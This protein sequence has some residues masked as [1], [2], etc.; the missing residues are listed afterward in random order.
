MFIARRSF[1]ERYQKMIYVLSKGR[2]IGGKGWRG[3]KGGRKG[4]EEQ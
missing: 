1:E 2:S 4:Y 3:F